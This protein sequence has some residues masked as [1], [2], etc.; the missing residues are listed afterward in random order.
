MGQHPFDK[1]LKRMNDSMS[2]ILR[3]NNNFFGG[4]DGVDI[5]CLVVQ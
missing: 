4:V 1:C 5:L 3:K 2:F